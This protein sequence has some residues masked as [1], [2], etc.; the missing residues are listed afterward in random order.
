LLIRALSGAVGGRS[1]LGP[2]RALLTLSVAIVLPQAAGLAW[3]EPATDRPFFVRWVDTGNNKAKTSVDYLH[4]V[5]GIDI[6]G[7]EQ[8]SRTQRSA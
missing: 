5:V 1:M 8:N 3:A 7:I 4:T 2:S 6:A